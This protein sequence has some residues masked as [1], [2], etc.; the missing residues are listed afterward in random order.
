MTGIDRRLPPILAQRSQAFD[1]KSRSTTN[2]LAYSRAISS[3]FFSNLLI[4]YLGKLLD[5]L[6]FQAAIWSG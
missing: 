3:Q 5:C 4:K 1:K 2:V 6:A